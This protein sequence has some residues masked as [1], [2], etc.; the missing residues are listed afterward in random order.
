M[1]FK[2]GIWQRKVKKEVKNGF[3]FDYSLLFVLIFIVG[4]RYLQ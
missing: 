4:I 3:Y 1:S 2:G